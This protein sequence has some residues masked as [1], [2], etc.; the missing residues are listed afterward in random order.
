M[1]LPEP[2]A[3]PVKGRI[4]LVRVDFNVPLQDGRI[5]DDYRIRESLPTIQWVLRQGGT[6]LLLSHLGRP[7][8]ERRVE[9]SLRPV[10]E[11]LSQLLKMP[12]G[13][14]PE[15]SGKRDVRDQKGKKVVLLLE[16]LRFHPGEEANDPSFARRLAELGEGFIQEAF[17]VCHRAHASVA[18]LPGLLPRCAG[19]RLL[20]EVRNL[21]RIRENPERPFV[22]I[23]GGKKLSE[24]VG[25]LRAVA[26]KADVVVAVGAV[27]NTFLRAAGKKV[28]R[29]FLEEEMV[30]TARA[31]LE[32]LPR[33]GTEVVLPADVVLETEEGEIRTMSVNEIPEDAIIGDVGPRTRQ[34]VGKLLREAATIFWAGPPGIFEREEFQ[35]GARA[36]LE[37]LRESQGFRC[38]GGGDT[39]AMIHRLGGEEAVDFLSTGGG[40]ALAFVA[41]ERLPGLEALL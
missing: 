31:L 21:L 28:G 10:A 11:H 29:S 36:L 13:F 38:T 30:E 20:E 7:G 32:E 18:R 37:A 35:E 15:I 9:L 12:V 19:F 41:G 5:E 8:G 26:G 14:L 34:E 2:G 17:S 33:Q 22:L 6:P 27:G 1:K 3:F 40:A 23:A 39:A 16:N 25:L 4:T 24:K